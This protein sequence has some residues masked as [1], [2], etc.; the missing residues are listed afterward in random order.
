M[1]GV[2]GKQTSETCRKAQNVKA[3]EMP[4]FLFLKALMN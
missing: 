4:A 3:I 2:R 1:Q